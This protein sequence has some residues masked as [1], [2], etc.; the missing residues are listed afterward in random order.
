M[1][2]WNN[3][4]AKRVY[5]HYYYHFQRLSSLLY[6]IINNMMNLDRGAKLIYTV[7]R[8]FEQSL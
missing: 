7:V 4:K 8:Q 1:F 2:G 5:Y 3:V 6:H